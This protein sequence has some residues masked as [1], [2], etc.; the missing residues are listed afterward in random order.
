MDLV[1]FRF[2][3]FISLCFVS[4]HFVSFSSRFRLELFV[5]FRSVG[6]ITRSFIRSF[7]F[8]SHSFRSINPIPD[9]RS[10]KLI[11]F[12]D[13]VSGF[14]RRH[15]QPYCGSNYCDVRHIQNCFVNWLYC[16]VFYCLSSTVCWFKSILSSNLDL[17]GRGTNTSR[18]ALHLTSSWTLQLRK[19][20]GE[21]SSSF[22]SLSL[23]GTNLDLKWLRP[24]FPY[25]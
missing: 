25:I 5:S 12:V 3:R 20:C 23:D 11:S 6:L 13:Y 2:V 7:V 15:K 19:I 22:G 17:P 8:D 4:I 14:T 16:V 10:S 21:L 9:S 24:I 18:N 1:S